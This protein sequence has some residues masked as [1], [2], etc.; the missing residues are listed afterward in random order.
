MWLLWLL[1]AVNVPRLLLADAAAPLR[2]AAG[3]RAFGV[4]VAVAVA[5]CVRGVWPGRDGRGGRACGRVAHRAPGHQAALAQ[6]EG[7]RR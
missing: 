1:R 4:A 2:L 5:R 6:L 7:Q 3:P